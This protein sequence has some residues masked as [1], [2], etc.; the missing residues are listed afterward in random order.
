MLQHRVGLLPG[1]GQELPVKESKKLDGP[2]CRAWEG[3]GTG[4]VVLCDA[5]V[6]NM[7]KKKND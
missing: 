4:G 3:G 5:R 1:N 7:K 2:M 6:T